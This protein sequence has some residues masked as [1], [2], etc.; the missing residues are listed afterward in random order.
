MSNVLTGPECLRTTPP[1]ADFNVLTRTTL[2]VNNLTLCD[3]TKT[4]KSSEANRYPVSDCQVVLD[5]ILLCRPAEKLK[6]LN[7]CPDK[8]HSASS[9]QP[10]DKS[11]LESI[12][13]KDPIPWPTMKESDK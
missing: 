6:T 11:Y 12:S 13:K 8:T 5:D 2:K 10:Y 3:F 9:R 1:D 4:S 7:V